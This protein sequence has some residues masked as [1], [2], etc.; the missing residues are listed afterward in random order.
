MSLYIQGAGEFLLERPGLFVETLCRGLPR[1]PGEVVH[2]PELDFVVMALHPKERD[3]YRFIIFN[4]STARVYRMILH[5]VD[6]PGEPSE[7]A[8][9]EID[10]FVNLLFSGQITQLIQAYSELR[11]VWTKITSIWRNP[12][13]EQN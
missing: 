13:S 9:E 8:K 2:L 6:R 7:I 10:G 5:P 3:R 4:T 12:A 1:L 11:G